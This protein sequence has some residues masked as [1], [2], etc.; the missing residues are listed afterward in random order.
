[1]STIPSI[2]QPIVVAPTPTPFRDDADQSLDF[3]ALERNVGRWL[4]TPLSGFVVVTANGEET[5]LSE[6]ERLQTV[7]T[8]SAAHNGQ[9]FVIAGVDER[10]TIETLRLSE[11]Y[12]EA[13]ADFIRMRIPRNMSPADLVTYYSYVTSR[14]PLPVVVIHQTFARGGDPAAP[15]PVIAELCGMDNVFAYITDHSILFEQ[16]VIPNIPSNV[17]KWNCSGALLAFG[18]MIGCDGACMLLG[19]IAPAL[20]MDIVSA[21]FNGDYKT[22]VELQR[23]AS[24]LNAIVMNTIGAPKTAMSMLGWEYGD[25]RRPTAPVSDESKAAIEAVLRETGLLA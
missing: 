20:C 6:A 19:N 11:N 23:T 24:K 25:P 3:D 17:R 1:M 5:M 21:G 14:C 12:A 4:D 8:V 18:T 9:K 13:G 15:P 2:D 10:S 7:K 22:A 16:Q